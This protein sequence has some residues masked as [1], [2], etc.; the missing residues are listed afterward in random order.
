MDELRKTSNRKK[1][2]DK[3]GRYRT[4]LILAQGTCIVLALCI[5][6][7]VVLSYVYVGLIKEFVCS[8]FYA[9]VYWL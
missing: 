1:K 3:H 6:D 8:I 7:L 2:K 5:S 9:L 4:Y